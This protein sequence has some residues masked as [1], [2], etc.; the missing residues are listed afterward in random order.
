MKFR[1]ILVP[2]VARYDAD[3]L[4]RVSETALRAGLQLGQALDAHVAVTCFAAAWHDPKESLVFGIPGGAIEQLLDE[5]D[6]RNAR[7]FSHARTIYESMV[8]EFEADR[9]D[10]PRAKVG[11]SVSFR[12]ITEEISLAAGAQGRRA[13]IAVLAALPKKHL[14]LHR[15][16]L[17]ALLSGSGRPLLVVPQN[18]RKLK[19]KHVVVAWN[20]SVEASRALF[21]AGSFIDAAKRVSL[22]CIREKK[23]DN[24][25]DAIESYLGW[26][27]PDAKVVRAELGRRSLPQAL[28]AEVKALDADLLV[29]G[30][31]TRGRFRQLVVGGAT[32]AMLND[33]DLPIFMMD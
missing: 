10:I 19:L 25:S 15:Q 31:E 9:C 33:P 11:F 4:E 20:D 21:A 24:F 18:H 28:R 29:M 5:I 27:R 12:E 8:K 17:E 13:D 2:L 23:G 7:C 16:L 3:A 32:D 30:A 1:K 14:G 22:L 26:H 6:K